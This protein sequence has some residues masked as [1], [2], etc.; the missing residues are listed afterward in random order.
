M[1]LLITGGAGFIGSN[2]IRHIIDRPEV[3]QLINLDTLTYAGN[4]G[5]LE[6]IHDQHPKY[7]FEQV[8]LRNVPE[9]HRVV[10]MHGITH[11]IHLAAE[12]HVDRSIASAGVFM[13]TNVLGTLHLLDACRSQW[14]EKTQEKEHRFIQ[15]STDE[16]YGSL[17]MDEA[18]FTEDSPLLPNSPYAASKAAAD[19]LV[20][21]YIK[22]HG[23]PAIITRCCNN[24]GPNQ[25]EEKLIPTV[26][27]CLRDRCLI[28]VYGDGQQ[29][30][31]WIHVTDHAEALWQ[32]LMNGETGEIY[33]VGTGEERTNLD[34]VNWLCDAFDAQLP[35]SGG[36][37]R[38]L[39]S[40]VTDRPGHDSRYAVNVSKIRAAVGWE[41]SIPL[42][43]KFTTFC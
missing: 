40:L 32:V 10:Q 25:H 41:A 19:C 17:A 37:S 36:N 16:V 11:V 28:P 14:G 34:L 5:N 23:F 21:S 42:S 26:L 27:K 33:N 29:M 4:L 24:Y 2:L 13:E 18:P 30:R 31:E 12:S 9:V 1:N 15:V 20:R 3:A 22:T 35:G 38:A 7:A 43:R 39:V 6:G 8:D